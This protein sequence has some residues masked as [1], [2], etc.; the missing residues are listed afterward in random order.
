MATHSHGRHIIPSAQTIIAQT[1]QDFELLVIGDDCTDDTEQAIAPLLYERV[2]W[3]N[4]TQRDSSQ[5][6]PNN[7]GL[8]RGPG[9]PYRRDQNAWRIRHRTSATT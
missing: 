1:L 8:E 4:L 7:A 3:L 9:S 5:T 2:H 6:F